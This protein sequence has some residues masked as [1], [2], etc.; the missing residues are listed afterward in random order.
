LLTDLPQKFFRMHKPDELPVVLIVED[1][2]DNAEIM[3]LY[4]R[5]RFRTERAPDANTAIRMAGERQFSCILMD[6]NLGPGMDGLKATIEIRKMEQY[7]RVPIVAITGYT[8]AG[9]RE[10]LLEGGCDFYLGKPFSQQG[11]HDLMMKVFTN[12]LS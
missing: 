1:N 4:L 12:N 3:K 2:N 7:S 9:D 5:G 8:M 10:K 11:L 6:I